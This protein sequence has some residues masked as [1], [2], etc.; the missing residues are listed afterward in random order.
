MT[1]LCGDFIA[2]ESFRNPVIN[3]L[4]DLLLGK[5]QSKGKFLLNNILGLVKNVSSLEG[6]PFSSRRVWRQNAIRSRLL[7]SDWER[8][9]WNRA[10]RAFRSSIQ[11][12]RSDRIPARTESISAL[13]S[14][15]RIFVWIFG[16]SAD[17]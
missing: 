13:V 3:I 5:L 17:R 14:T 6:S 12:I 9:C 4:P 10:T 7:G 8:I 2:V 16:L 15:G 1:K 11:V